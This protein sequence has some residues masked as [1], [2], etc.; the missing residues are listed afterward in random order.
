MKPLI[1]IT[2]NF[3]DDDKYGIA[4]DLGTKG[5]SLNVLAKDY[6]D[7]L[8][9][10]NSIPILIPCSYNRGLLNEYVKMCDGLILTGGNDINPV[11][12]GK[13]ADEHTGIIQDYRDDEEIF[14][15]N[16]F[17]KMKKP[18]LGICRGMEIINVALGGSLY[19]HLPDN[20]FKCHS[21]N[22]NERYKSV[23]EIVIDDDCSLFDVF[24]RHKIFVNSYHHQG[25]NKIA[26]LLK[27]VA[28]S[29]DGVV[30][31]IELKDSSENYILGVQWHPEMMAVNNEEQQIL[32]EYFVD[33]CRKN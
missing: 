25:L 28:V 17:F 18:I 7:M 31:G 13:R 27:T 15:F 26:T 5:Q 30:E 33:K 14:L 20:G 32:I 19:V 24:N 12:Y 4:M 11:R 8:L 2:C 3:T 21:I 10:S 22:S 29:D 16:N 9:K 6:I 1:G 23:H